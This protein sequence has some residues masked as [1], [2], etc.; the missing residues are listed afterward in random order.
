MDGCEKERYEI[1]YRPVVTS[2][3]VGYFEGFK[4]KT[5][6]VSLYEA[7]GRV[8]CQTAQVPTRTQIT[9]GYLLS[10]Q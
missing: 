5:A 1:C 4:L 9:S 2:L 10:H 6:S 3:F 8:F 7:L